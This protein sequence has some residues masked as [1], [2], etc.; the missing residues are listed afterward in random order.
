MG[1]EHKSKL[2]QDIITKKEEEEEEEE[3]INE[4][5]DEGGGGGEGEEEE[6]RET[7]LKTK[8]LPDHN[9]TRG[10]IALSVVPVCYRCVKSRVPVP[11]GVFMD[12]QV[13]QFESGESLKKCPS[14]HKNQE[15]IFVTGDT[16]GVIMTFDPFAY[17][18]DVWFIVTRRK[19]GVK[20]LW[21]RKWKDLR[22]KIA[23][24]PSMVC[25]KVPVFE[26]GVVGEDPKVRN[27][28]S[29]RDAVCFCIKIGD[30]SRQNTLWVEMGMFKVWS[31]TSNAEFE[32]F[33]T[34]YC[35]EVT[36]NMKY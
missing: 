9:G 30:M 17:D 19:N 27:L 4:G 33:V 8:G 18:D 11:E 14:S 5:E 34:R 12:I 25:E 15:R 36:I 31:S 28:A 29:L 23:S 20:R 10:S 13:F 7:L 2:V 22:T 6:P 35:G 16:V 32:S 24:V 1:S 3:Y 21:R 26:I